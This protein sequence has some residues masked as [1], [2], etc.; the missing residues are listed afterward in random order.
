MAMKRIFF[1]HIWLSA[2]V[3][4]L[5]GG[6]AA[7]GGGV[8]LPPPVFPNVVDTVTLFA[9]R[10]TAISQASGFDIIRGAV[11][12]TDRGE[13]FDFAFDFDS[14][15]TPVIAPAGV[16]GFPPQAGLRVSNDPFDEIDRAPEDDFVVDSTITLRPDLVFIAR[17]RS[18]GTGCAFLGP[19]PRYGKFRVLEIDTQE[20]SVTFEFLV[21]LN[22][23]FRGLEP[24]FPTN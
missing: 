16:L 11:A 14:T 7:C 5:I 13:I 22:C 9:L 23:G 6:M 2:A 4:A 17:S 18:D 8:N 20:R 3:A 21:D 1:S 15:E 19:L 24:G 10:G 12:R